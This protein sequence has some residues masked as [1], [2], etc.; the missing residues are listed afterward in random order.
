MDHV[1]P[2]EAYSGRR[3]KWQPKPESKMQKYFNRDQWSRPIVRCEPFSQGKRYY[4]TI[5]AA[6]LDLA[7]ERRRK[8][9]ALDPN[10]PQ[11]MED[12]AQLQ[13]NIR[14]GAVQREALGYGHRYHYIWQFCTLAEA[15]AGGAD[16]I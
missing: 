14:S 12:P 16:C 7:L 9:L 15:L 5:A 10:G 4:L 1:T 11:G 8:R 6:A 3:R 13:G 2:G